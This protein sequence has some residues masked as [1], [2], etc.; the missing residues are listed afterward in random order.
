M[1][2]NNENKLIEIQL[3]GAKRLSERLTVS[4][5]SA[6]KKKKMNPQVDDILLVANE[7]R[8]DNY[9]RVGRVVKTSSDE[10][11]N[12]WKVVRDMS[13]WSSPELIDL[14]TELRL[15]QHEELGDE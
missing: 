14:I 15:K 2:T 12:G 3:I 5:D 13:G 11:S 4:F 6:S 8:S 10:S 9:L 7:D 1:N